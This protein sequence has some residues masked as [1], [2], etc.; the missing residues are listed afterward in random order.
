MGLLP[1]RVE[2]CTCPA[3]YPTCWFIATSSVRGACFPEGGQRGSPQPP[4]GHCGGP[5][6]CCTMCATC[7][8]V[9]N[10]PTDPKKCSQPYCPPGTWRQGSGKDSGC[11][12]C[13]AGKYNPNANSV[14]ESACIPAS[15]GYVVTNQAMSEQQCAC[16]ARAQLVPS[17]CLALRSLLLV[18]TSASLARANPALHISSPQRVGL[19]LTPT[20]RA[21]RAAP[22]AQPARRKR[23]KAG[24]RAPTARPESTH[25][26]KEA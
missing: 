10:Q 26:R 16:P 15:A 18:C 14:S 21:R 22:C 11:V 2:S 23:R 13:A 4:E 5:R 24:L 20:H 25:R 1:V 12:E 8:T 9:K 7:K 6:E 17:S 19:G 3:G